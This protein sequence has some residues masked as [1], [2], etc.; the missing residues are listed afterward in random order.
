MAPP[1]AIRIDVREMLCA[2]ALAVVA[3]AMERLHGAE[4]ADVLYNAQDV[5][6]DLLIWAQ[7][8]G[9]TVEERSDSAL[10]LWRVPRTP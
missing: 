8:R 5:R 2:Q 4:L 9:Y 3:R 7:D 10:R 6:R 1:P